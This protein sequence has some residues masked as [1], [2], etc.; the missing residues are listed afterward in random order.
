[1]KTRKISRWFIPLLMLLI[2]VNIS[3]AGAEN[4]TG[5]Q[6]APFNSEFLES[7][8]KLNMLT[9]DASEQS[10]TGYW[11]APISLKHLTESSLLKGNILSLATSYDLRSLGRVTSVKDQGNCGSCWS[12]ATY[13]SM[14]SNILTSDS[15]SWDFSENNLKNTHGFDLTYDEGGNAFMSAAYLGRWSGPVTE[16]ADP[17]NDSSGV[18]PSGLTT[19]K[20]VQNVVFLPDRTSSTDNTAIKQAIVS[21][22]AVYV[23][24]YYGSSYYNSTHHA[25]YY[26]GSSSAN[27]A[28][29]VVG[30]DDNYSSSNFSSTPSGNGAFI[31]KNSWGS[32]WGESGYFYVSYYDKVFGYSENARFVTPAATTNYTNIYQY[33]PL[34][35]VSSVGY[36][37][38]TGWFA[39]IFT[40]TGTQSLKAVS[41]YTASTSNTYQIKIYTG[42]S[43]GPISGTL[44]YTQTGTISNAG[45]VTVPLTNA[46]SLTSGAKFSVVVKLIT[47]GYNYPIPVEVPVSGYSSAATASSGQS[48]ISSSGTSWTDLTN[49]Y[50]K[51]N[52]CLKAFTN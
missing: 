23:A 37:S 49:Y 14:E 41:F 25:Y 40:A 12:F 46:V 13:G 27:H 24:M 22:G 32:S 26:S 11:P 35:W 19:V 47:S 50:S 29:T 48:Y 5:L 1:M 6:R 2:V 38:N 9:Q 39:N 16:S 3:L 31:V 20:H 42:A 18:S 33:D 10:T 34:G 36:S 7:L 15:V 45:Y 51:G 4:V 44:A 17:Y 8:T 52:V 28:I 43:S 30:W 21:Y